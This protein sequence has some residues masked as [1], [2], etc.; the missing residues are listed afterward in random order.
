MNLLKEQLA[1]LEEADRAYKAASALDRHNSLKAK[2]RIRRLL[3]SPKGLSAAFG[4]GIVKGLTQS[5]D[6]NKSALKKTGAKQVL[7]MWLG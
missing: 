4:A 6:N 7:S 5:D 3:I 2:A 1:S